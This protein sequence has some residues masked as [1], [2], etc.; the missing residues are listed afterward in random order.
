MHYLTYVLVEDEEDLNEYSSAQL[1]G[2]VENGMARHEGDMWDWY[3]VG[4]RWDQVIPNNVLNVKDGKDEVIRIAREMSTS[5]EQEIAV[6]LRRI[7]GVLVTEEEALAT[8]GWHGLGGTPAPGYADRLN[9]EST[10]TNTLLKKVLEDPSLLSTAVG[11]GMV[12]F[13]GYRL[14]KLGS[15]LGNY[16][17]CGC[18]Y[19]DLH[20]GDHSPVALRLLAENPDEDTNNLWL[21]AVD[22]HN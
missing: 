3:V 15:A 17:Y 11:M 7:L 4:G 13:L 16:A 1:E 8:A 2:V 21:I 6:D 5:R 12:G 18:G 10:D 9:K 19:L 22:I 14:R 20:E